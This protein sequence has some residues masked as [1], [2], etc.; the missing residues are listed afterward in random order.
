[1]DARLKG[2]TALITAGST[3]I[4]VAIA[5]EL[6]AEGVDV[7]VASRNPD[8]T[9]IE[10]IRKKGVRAL[11]LRADVSQ[12]REVVDMI[13]TVIQEFGQLDL[14]VNNAAIALHE[15]PRDAS[16]LCSSDSSRLR[17]RLQARGVSIASKHMV[18]R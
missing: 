10:Q 1:M 15:P 12:E 3:G 18:S 8:Q 17:D 7:A 16:L 4:G 9:A 13:A 2:K 5:L 6:A 11:S 14:Y